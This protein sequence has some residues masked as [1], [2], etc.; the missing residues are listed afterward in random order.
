MSTALTP[1]RPITTQTRDGA[2]VH[3]LVHDQ[4][5]AREMTHWARIIVEADRRGRGYL[6]RV[7]NRLAAWLLQEWRWYQALQ[8]LPP[9]PRR[10]SRWV[11][12]V[13]GLIGRSIPIPI[14]ERR[15]G[16]MLPRRPSIGASRVMVVDYAR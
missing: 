2:V 14:R 12:H 5:H 10:F 3:V 7:A 8:L 1:P 4:A 11:V 16:M 6:R 9:Q 15:T 13:Y